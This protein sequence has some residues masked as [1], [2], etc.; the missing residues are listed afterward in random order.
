MLLPCAL[1]AEKVLSCEKSFKKEFMAC[2][3]IKLKSKRTLISDI[4][5]S[6]R[7]Y[8]SLNLHET[9]SSFSFQKVN[10]GHSMS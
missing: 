8:A 1:F 9:R 2:F 4:I 5:H 10:F 7:K 6:N 3:K